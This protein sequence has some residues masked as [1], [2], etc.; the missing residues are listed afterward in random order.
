[1]GGGRADPLFDPVECTGDPGDG[2]KVPYQWYR[3]TIAGTG[4]PARH[5]LWLARS[6]VSGL[7]NVTLALPQV[8]DPAGDERRAVRVAAA[9]FKYRKALAALAYDEDE[10]VRRQARLTLETTP[11]ARRSVVQGVIACAATAIVL[12]LLV[13]QVS[14]SLGTPAAHSSPR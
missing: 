10:I 6:S 14:G 8:D 5:P 9:R 7:T 12:V 13:L 1:G 4:V 11:R 3:D 2:S